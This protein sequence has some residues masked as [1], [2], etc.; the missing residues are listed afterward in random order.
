MVQTS[1]EDGS[2]V[3]IVL[4]KDLKGDLI[5]VSRKSDQVMSIDLGLEQMVVNPL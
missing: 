5:S 4:S 2:G 3:G 1:T